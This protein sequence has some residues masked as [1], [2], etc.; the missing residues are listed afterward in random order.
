MKIALIGYGKMGKAIE[1]VAQSRGHEIIMKV[2]SSNKNE[3]TASNL[4]NADVAIEFTEPSSALRNIRECFNAG[5]PV[6]TGTTGWN[7]H[8]NELNEM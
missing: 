2:T 1:Q 5:T 6:I 7:K 8:I 4:Q 3:A